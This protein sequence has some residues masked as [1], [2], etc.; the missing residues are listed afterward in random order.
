MKNDGRCTIMF[1]IINKSIIA[2]RQPVNC[3]GNYIYIY[4]LN[5]PRSMWLLSLTSTP[6][7][8]HLTIWVLTAPLK[9][10]RTEASCAQ[11]IV[12]LHTWVTGNRC[13]RISSWWSKCLRD[14]VSPWIVHIL[15]LIVQFSKKAS[16]IFAHLGTM[17]AVFSTCSGH[18]KSIC[19]VWSVTKKT[20][21]KVKWINGQFVVHL[22]M[23]YF[24]TGINIKLL[25]LA[26]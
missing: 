12:Q 26:V 4:K 14:G 24:S 10:N 8:V 2:C 13:S 15:I 3:S 5:S 21:H 25:V 23:L 18:C 6:S 22:R 7:S 19:L 9:S 20:H 16:S 11:A 1:S 17:A